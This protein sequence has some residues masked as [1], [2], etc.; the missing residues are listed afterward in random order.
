VVHVDVATGVGREVAR[1]P[2]VWQQE[3]DRPEP[4]RP[5]ALD[6]V[7]GAPA[8]AAHRR[9]VVAS[10][11]LLEPVGARVGVVV[12]ERD[13]V[14]GREREADLPRLGRATAPMGFRA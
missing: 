4:R 13:E 14:L 9:V 5:L 7:Q 3:A 2:A 1:E 12:E 8:D 10:P 6:A 11:E